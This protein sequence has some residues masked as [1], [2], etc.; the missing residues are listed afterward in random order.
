MTS[1]CFQ[2]SLSKFYYHIPDSSKLSN[3][4]HEVEKAKCSGIVKHKHLKLPQN[5][6]GGG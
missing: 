6:R 2:V 1:I 4:A 3:H 5:L